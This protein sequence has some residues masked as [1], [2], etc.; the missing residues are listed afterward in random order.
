MSKKKSKTSKVDALA[1]QATAELVPAISPASPG[2]AEAGKIG[3]PPD[4]FFMLE[5]PGCK[6]VHFRHAGYV[7]QLV[8]II[9]AG[10]GPMLPDQQHA[11]NVCVACKRCF[12]RDRVAAKTY[13]ITDRIDLQA[14]DKTEREMH[15]A[16]GPGGQ[17]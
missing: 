15:K 6:G 14:W 5:C 11:V 4:T 10:R 3:P 7:S 12:V 2:F 17:C 8:P 16:T 1:I 9:E 13:D